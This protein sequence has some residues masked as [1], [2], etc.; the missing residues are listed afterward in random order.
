MQEILSFAGLDMSEFINQRT[1]AKIFRDR[2]VLQMCKDPKAHGHTF[3]KVKSE[4][5]R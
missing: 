1:N 2:G 5:R 4:C 3:G